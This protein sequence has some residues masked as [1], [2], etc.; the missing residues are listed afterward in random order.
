MGLQVGVTG[1]G[2]QLQSQGVVVHGSVV[3]T[4]V[5][6]RPSGVDLQFRHRC[7]QRP[8]D[9]LGTRDAKQPARPRYGDAT[10]LRVDP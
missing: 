7:Y 3:K 1:F 5:R 6:P 8:L 10:Q 2:G 4:G 9:R